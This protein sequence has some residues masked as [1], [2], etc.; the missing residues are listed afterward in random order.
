LLRLFGVT[1]DDTQ[2]GIA[3]R[4]LAIPLATRRA[5]ATAVP[6]HLNAS[7]VDVDTFDIKV[8][9]FAE[10]VWFREAA[11]DLIR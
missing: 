6:C 4:A 10:Q 3:L 8:A 1:S 5:V 11:K 9:Q 2:A 7:A